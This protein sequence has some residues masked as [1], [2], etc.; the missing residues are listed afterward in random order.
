MIWQNKEI[1]NGKS[2][3]LLVDG[4]LYVADDL[5]NFYIFDAAS[6]KQIGKPVKLVGTIVRASPLYADGKI[7]MCSTSGWHVFQPTANGLKL[8]DRMRLDAADEISG[9]PIVSH[10]RIYL[11]TSSHMYCLAKPDT[12][13]AATAIPPGPVETP[14]DVNDKPAQIQIVPCDVMLQAGRKQEFEVRLFNAK[15]QLV[16]TQPVEFQLQGPGEITPGGVFTAASDNA[17]TAT[18][19][20][21]KLGDV[22]GQARVRVVPPL[23]WK[24]DFNDITLSGPNNTGDPPVT[25]VGMRYR[26]QIRDVDGNKVMVK[27]TT[28]PK[29]TKSQ[30]WIGPP[31][32]HDYTIQADFRASKGSIMP[33]MGLV[34]Q[35]YTLDLMGANQQ[36]QIRSWTAQIHTNFSKSVPYEWQIEKWYTMKFK[37][38]NEGGKAVL[39]GKVWP[40][41]EKEPPAWTIEAADENPNV[42]GSPGFYGESSNSEIQIDNVT[43]TAN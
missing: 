4:R 8:V 20:T 7:Y 37:A 38:A 13:P 34:A 21:A 28:I 41:D 15:G 11:P 43:V 22:T 35:R 16:K 33:D 27:I 30:G 12:V 1:G 2:S 18:I 23:P 25:W 26:H 17:H 39:R 19:I 6:G 10:G 9:S 42:V 29:G 24:F 32:L 36:L 5:G 14:V 40:R 31:E 3:P